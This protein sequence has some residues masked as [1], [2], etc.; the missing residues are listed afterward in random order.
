[1]NNKVKFCKLASCITVATLTLSA[2]SPSKEANIAGSNLTL[3]S[4]NELSVESLRS[5]HY[6]SEITIEKLLNNT[7]TD[8]EYTKHYFDTNTQYHSYLAS[9][10]S[11]QLS[12]Y[13]RIDVPNSPMPEQGY[14]VVMFI[15]GWIGIKNAPSYDF[16][17]Q[18]NT[19]YADV[20]D[21][22]VKQG[23]VV[24]TPGLRGHGTVNGIPAQGIEYMERWDNPTYLSPMFYT[25]DALNLLA[26]IPSLE[27][28]NWQDVNLQQEQIKIN[29]S[30]INITG[31][32]QGGDVALTALAVSGEGS[33]IETP[34]N[35]GAIWAGCFLPPL[36]QALLYGPMG[37]TTEAFLSGDGTWTASAI[38][39][40]GE[41]NPNFRFAYPPDWIGT[42]DN[43]NNDWSWQKD[44]WAEESVKA[45]LTKRFNIMYN[46]L[47]EHVTAFNDV[48]YSVSID[49]E[50]KVEF[51]ND[52]QVYEQ[53]Q[54][55]G[56]FNFPE[57]L[58][59]P[60]ALHHSDRDYYSPSIWN[61]RLVS[62]INAVG[63]NASSFEYIGNTHSLS[64]S[65]K[66]WFSPKGSK[67]GFKE[68]VTRNAKLFNNQ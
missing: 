11:D 24:L 58:T 41:I 48:N 60:L 6:S 45:S 23:F 68:M 67:S 64:I 34:F 66:P 42:P 49:T 7:T 61:K 57:Y 54:N 59:E 22:Y 31:H 28:I 56:G 44:N 39:K 21:S 3:S 18:A 17:Y 35:A 29:K 32:S 47:N 63:G 33:T 10:P 40:N 36:E 37:N 38:G 20:I 30:K 62:K 53:Y 15:H 16:N 5:R 4:L 46:T 9:Y 1:M 26:G 50:G 27:Q 8:N 65:D 12:V 51:V 13:T 25:I 14:P 19:N 52:P 2:C 43:S 55:I